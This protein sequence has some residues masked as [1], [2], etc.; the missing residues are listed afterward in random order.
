MPK[1]RSRTKRPAPVLEAPA[2]AP[3]PSARFN[4]PKDL[5]LWLAL[6]AAAWS[7]AN[8]QG[9]QLGGEGALDLGVYSVSM[10]IW[11]VFSGLWLW[12]WLRGRHSELSMDRTLAS[13][14]ALLALLHAVPDSATSHKLDTV[15]L[16]AYVLGALAGLYAASGPALNRPWQPASER[17]PETPMPRGL[18][19]L[20]LGLLSLGLGWLTWQSRGFAA[21]HLRTNLA[22][23]ALFLYF[24]GRGGSY[25]GVAGGPPPQMAQ[26]VA[27]G[28]F[29]L[30]CMGALLWLAAINRAKTGT[31]VAA[32]F[33]AGILGKLNLAWISPTG[34]AHLGQKIANIG[35]AYY[36]LAPRVEAYGLWNFVLDFNK[37]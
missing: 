37:L 18:G 25:E 28:I 6:G 17:A 23:D 19:L 5:N 35:T 24:M 29:F 30:G 27:M 11:S 36:A 31:L 9:S 26:Y 13:I 20:S 2:M 1:P 10:L 3:Q 33:F 21:T 34:F 12:A 22:S 14:V 16:A 4:L 7:L 32:L 15:V 8:L